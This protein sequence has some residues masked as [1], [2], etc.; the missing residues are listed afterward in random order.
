M[1]NHMNSV[2]PLNAQ[3]TKVNMLGE[4]MNSIDR[5]YYQY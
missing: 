3:S 2:G 4:H 5:P 1:V